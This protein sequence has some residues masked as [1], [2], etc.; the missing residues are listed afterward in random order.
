[1]SKKSLKIEKPLL[2][3]HFRLP[4]FVLLF[5]PFPSWFK[6]LKINCLARSPPCVFTDL[7]A[8]VEQVI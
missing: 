3:E 8:P 2:Q 6:I 5:P 7:T 4:S 1:M